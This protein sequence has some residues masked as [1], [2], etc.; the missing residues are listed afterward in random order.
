LENI[1]ELNQSDTYL[2]GQVNTLQDILSHEPLSM[3]QVYQM[4]SSLKDV[5]RKQGQL[6]TS[7]DEAASSLRSLLDRF[8]S[9]PAMMTDS[10][11]DFQNKIK[12][13]S[14]R[15]K[16]SQNVE[17]LGSIIGLL[18]EDTSLMQLDLTRSRDE[19]L[20]A[21]EQ[22]EAAEQRIAEL[23]GALEAASAK[24]REDQ[25]T[26]AFNRRGLAEH[27]QREISR[28]ERTGAPLSLALLD[29]DNFKQ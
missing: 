10:T 25:L 15:I 1:A 23:E 2:V 29:V 13:H 28:A 17:E 22:V 21:K 5:I 27:F 7:L 3:Q 6:K 8:I 11:D 24:V 26:G 4:E 19:L 18:M 16:Q 14:D 9:R 20:S 12:D